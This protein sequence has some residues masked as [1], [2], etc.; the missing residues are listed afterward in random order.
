MP[1]GANDDY[2]RAHCERSAAIVGEWLRTRGQPTELVARGRAADPACTRSA[3]APTPTSLQAADS[4]SFLEVNVDARRRAGCATGRCDLERAEAT[5]TA[6]CSSGSALAQR[7]RARRRPCYEEALAVA[8]RS[9]S[10]SRRPRSR[11]RSRSRPSTGTRRPSSPAARSSRILVNQRLLAP[12][13]RSSRCGACPG[14]TG[15]CEAAASCGS[16]RWRPTGRSSGRRS[17]A[18]GWPALA[19]AFSVVASPTRAQPGDGRR[20]AR[21]RRLRLRSARDARRRS[22]PGSSPGAVRG[23]REIAGRGADRSALRDLARAR[24]ADRRGARAGGEHRAAYRKFRSRSHEDRPCVGGRCRA[25]GRASCGSSSAPSPSGPS[26]SPSSAQRRRRT[27]SARPTPRRSSR[28][29]T[30]AA[31]PPTVGA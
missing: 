23:E 26:S 15:S 29:P 4:I 13:E 5:S 28:S 21:R 10:G 3:A 25:G 24:R 6:G 14:S 19:G 9:L 7:A 27:R 31:R 30:C 17:C 18:S 22:A 20:R 16:G 12:D 8:T 1:P 11:R 2:R